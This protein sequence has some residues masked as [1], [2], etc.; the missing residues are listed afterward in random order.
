MRMITTKM[1]FSRSVLLCP[2]FWM[3]SFILTKMK[4]FT[5]HS[6][7]LNIQLLMIKYN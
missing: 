3:M 4:I 6:K 1:F 2:N 5:F 7:I